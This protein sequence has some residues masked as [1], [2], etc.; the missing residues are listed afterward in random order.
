MRH[1]T[2]SHNVVNP[3]SIEENRLYVKKVT[4]RKNLSKEAYI[5]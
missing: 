3:S 2:R 5:A 1:Y 4:N